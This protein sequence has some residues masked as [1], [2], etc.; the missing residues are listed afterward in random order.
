MGQQA[1]GR[2][3]HHSTTKLTRMHTRQWSIWPEGEVR[4]LMS[5]TQAPWMP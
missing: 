3:L 2:F 4:T 5:L 1:L